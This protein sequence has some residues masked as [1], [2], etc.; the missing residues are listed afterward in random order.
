MDAA[1]PSSRRLMHPAEDEATEPEDPYRAYWNALK[2]KYATTNLL[3]SYSLDLSPLPPNWAVITINVTEDRTTMFISRHQR[4]HQPLIFCLPLDRQGRREG[5]ADDDLFTFDAGC[6][7]MNDI[8]AQSDAGARGAK[9]IVELQDKIAW[10]DLRFALDK[11]MEELVANMEFVWLGAFKVR[12]FYK[13][14]PA[15]LTDK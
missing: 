7:E 1:S 12:S 13:H 5:D 11:R 3:T 10:W 4:D 14:G 2:T 15:H 8:V 6:A 9:N